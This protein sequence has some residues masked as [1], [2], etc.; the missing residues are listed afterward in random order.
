MP[1]K[2]PYEV[3]GIEPNASPAEI[4]SAYRS[5]ARRYHPDVNPNDKDAEDKF[6]EVGAAYAILNDPEKRKHFDQFGTDPA[7]PHIEH[8]PT[9]PSG[10]SKGAPAAPSNPIS[11]G[12]SDIVEEY[13]HKIR[14]KIT[15]GQFKLWDEFNTWDIYKTGIVNREIKHPR[16]QTNPYKNKVAELEG[17]ITKHSDAWEKELHNLQDGY[18][19]NNDKLEEYVRSY[20][21]NILEKANRNP[22]IQYSFSLDSSYA[23]REKI[24]RGIADE[25][26]ELIDGSLQEIRIPDF[27]KHAN[28]LQIKYTDLIN[29]AAQRLGITFL[30]KNINR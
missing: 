6:K 22:M 7:N 15:A 13:R 10:A 20:M 12:F 28:A 4:K 1:S 19:I 5:L 18:D 29:R 8:A 3:L 17:I 2:N 27:I 24:F 14:A 16:F 25:R 30:D 21:A 23:D 9:T 26:L 11:N